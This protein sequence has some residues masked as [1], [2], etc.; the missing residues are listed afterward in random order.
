MKN[1]Y[2]VR[3]DVTAIF[4][5][6]PKYG[7]LETF[8]DTQD[9]PRVQE[10]PNK[11][12]ARWDPSIN[13]FYC[14][15]N[16][17]QGTVIMHRWILGAPKNIHVDHYNHETLENVKSNLR[18]LTNAENQQNRNGA[19]KQSKSGIRGVYWNKQHKKWRA[20]I[21]LN[22]KDI[23]LGYFDDIQEAKRIVMD[24]RARNMPFSKEA[25][26]AR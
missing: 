9:L 1:D 16:S 13:G 24:A 18:L 12:Y 21:G 20:Q 14:V 6:S 10:F 23:F 2:E 8:I 7:P 11:W 4:L 25:M 17:K 15:G 3:G 5:N 19:H 26:K 22:G